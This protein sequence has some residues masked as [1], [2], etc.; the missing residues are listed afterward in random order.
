MIFCC[1]SV[2]FTRS[3]TAE[4]R[5][6]LILSEETPRRHRGDT[7]K[8]PKRHR[9]DTSETPR[10]HRRDTSETPQRLCGDTSK[11]RLRDT[12]EKERDRQRERQRDRQTDRQTDRRTETDTQR[13][14]TDGGA[15]EVA[16]RHL[17]V[18]AE[19]LH[20]AAKGETTL[21]PKHKY[22]QNKT[23]K[24][25][26]RISQQQNMQQQQ[27]MQQQQNMQQQQHMQQ[28]ECAYP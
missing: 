23:T 5:A 20:T 13:H 25:A 14:P 4:R 7:L 6:Q 26:Y 1:L 24:T 22:P 2:S 11:R 12:R 19:T 18:S 17:K 27:H 10:R 16:Q 28:Q 15:F 3:F 9:R 21:S 8:T